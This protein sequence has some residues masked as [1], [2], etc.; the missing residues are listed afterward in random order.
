M[1]STLRNIKSRRKSW[2]T[3][4]T[5]EADF[6]LFVQNRPKV[7]TVCKNNPAGCFVALVF[8]S[9][10]SKYTLLAHYIWPQ[11]TLFSLFSPRFK[12]AMS[13]SRVTGFL[14]A[15]AY[16]GEVST[17]EVMEAQRREEILGFYPYF[18]I[19]HNQGGTLVRFTRRP[20]FTHKEIPWYSFLLK[21]DWPA[22][23]LNANR[24]Y[25]SL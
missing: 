11:W 5:R 2:G 8:A 4:Y 20:Q 16:K 17:Q 18:D 12:T 21:A 14:P 23:L 10:P 13:C 24:K 15:V 22:V 1:S 9:R 25:R 19:R 6:R 3:A 7:R